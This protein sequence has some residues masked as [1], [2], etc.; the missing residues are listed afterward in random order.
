[1]INIKIDSRK[2]KPGDIFVALPGSTVDGHDFVSKA[3]ENGAIKAVVE[4]KVKCDI[5]QAI[6]VITIKIK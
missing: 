3:Y 5:E 1:M 2:I 4:H 6:S